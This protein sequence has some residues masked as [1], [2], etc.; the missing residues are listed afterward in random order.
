MGWDLL[1]YEQVREMLTWAKE[2]IYAAESYL[3]EGLVRIRND[4]ERES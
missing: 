3:R 2:F 4:W 1:R